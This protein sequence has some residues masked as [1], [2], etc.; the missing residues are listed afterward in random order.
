[1]SAFS[2]LYKNIDGIQ[3]KFLAFWDVVSKRFAKNPYV[4]G[5]DPINEP[6]PADFYEDPTIVTEH[7]KYDR[8]TL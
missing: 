2:R 1:M 3:D 6:F 7:G 5:Y 8:E 4:I